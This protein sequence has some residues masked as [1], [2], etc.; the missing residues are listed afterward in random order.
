MAR[1]VPIAE[2]VV[3]TGGVSKN[4]GVV[5]A[6]SKN[7]GYDIQVSE[8]SQIAG[9]LGAGASRPGGRGKGR[10]LNDSA[11][12][13]ASRLSCINKE[14]STLNRYPVVSR[15]PTRIRLYALSHSHTH[16]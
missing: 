5:K 1:R 2:D 7:L 10:G 16:G 11:G 9:A 3:L 4:V 6:L 8:L 13:A 14:V 15:L 12:G